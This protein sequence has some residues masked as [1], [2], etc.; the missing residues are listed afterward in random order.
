MQQSYDIVTDQLHITTLKTKPK[1][2]VISLFMTHTLIN[3]RTTTYIMA[4]P[5][6][7]PPVQEHLSIDAMLEKDDDFDDKNDTNLIN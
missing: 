3:N 5:A 7:T 4:P 2:S 6:P 1:G